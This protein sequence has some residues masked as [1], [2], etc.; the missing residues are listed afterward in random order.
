MSSAWLGQRERGSLAAMRLMTWITLA[1]GYRIARALLYPICLYFIA[2]SPRARRASRQYL[3]RVLG[4]R[5]AFGDVFRQ[6]HVFASTLHD[7]IAILSGRTGDIDVRVHGYAAL[8]ALLARGRGCLLLGSHLGSFEVLRVVGESRRR[9]AINLVMYEGNARKTSRWLRDMAPELAQRIIA[10]GTPGTLL[11]VRECL[12]RGEIVAML[13]DRPFNGE[14]MVECEFLGAAA[15][16]P[17]GPLLTAALLKAPVVLFFCLHRDAGR[18]DAY[19]EPLAEKI[20]IEE[21]PREAAVA[22][23]VV[24]Y[25]NRLEA[26]ARAAPYNWFNFYDFW[27]SRTK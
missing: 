18:Y 20:D 3:A 22:P 25:V 7:R 16:F 14:R 26:H 13:G 4:R 23:W 19:L 10:P 11:R 6:F 12:E 24:R 21:G 9:L 1:L 8:E 15:S 2:F 17:S 5:P 27:K